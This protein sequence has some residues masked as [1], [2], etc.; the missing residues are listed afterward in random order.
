MAPLLLYKSV[1]YSLLRKFCFNPVKR[2]RPDPDTSKVF[3][4][5]GRVARQISRK[6]KVMLL[7]GA[8][9]SLD[10]AEKVDVDRCSA[11]DEVKEA[12]S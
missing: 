5:R 12:K 10:R 2:N 11:S 8:K 1:S 3:T 9:G 7:V 6:Q 4:P